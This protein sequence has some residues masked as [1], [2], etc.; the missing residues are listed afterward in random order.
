M[1]IKQILDYQKQDF[2]IIKLERKLEESE[3]KKIYQEMRTVVKDAQNKSNNLEKEAGELI[4]Q[5]TEMKKAY[6]AE[7]K[8]CGEIVNKDP[9]SLKVEDLDKTVSKT[10]QMIESISLLEKKLM[11]FAEHVNSV[12]ADFDSTRKRYNEARKK[13]SAHKQAYEAMSAKILPE[14]EKLKHEIKK[15]EDKMDPAFLQKYKQRRQDKVFPIFVPVVDKTCGGCRMELPSA[16]LD[17]LKRNGFLECEHC[18][19]IIYN[20]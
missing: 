16:S 9:K 8:A 5:Y 2:E 12:L 15:I 3:D 13:Y 1:D 20:A 4:K 19:R 7:V 11:A 6:D 17:R 10:N 14:I 18:R